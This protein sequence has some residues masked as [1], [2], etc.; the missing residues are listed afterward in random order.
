MISRRDFTT[1]ALLGTLLPRPA[2]AG[3]HAPLAQAWLR[4][5][6]ERCADLR[7]ATLPATDWQDAVEA[8][9]GKVSVGDLIAATDFEKLARRLALPD[10]QANTVDPAFPRVA[11]VSDRPYHVRIFGMRQGRAIIPHGHRN[12]ASMHVVLRGEFHLR[13]FE[14]VR[15]DKDAL[16]VRPTI[17]R[18]AKP[19]DRSTISDARDNV[20]WL[21]AT[22]GP[23]YTLDI[24]V[25]SLGGKD[26]AMDFVDPASAT[27]DGDALRMPRLDVRAA[28]A[29]YG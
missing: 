27:Q 29:R 4:Q 2:F 21:V 14:R 7:S 1:W 19:G 15:D 22:K 10:D 3:K 25:A 16:V 12:M 24:I 8:L 26:W 28:I 13:H 23:A 11:G 17:D 18:T 20:H 5:L 9:F 6:H